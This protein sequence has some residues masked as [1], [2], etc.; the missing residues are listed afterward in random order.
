MKTSSL[1]NQRHQARQIQ[2]YHPAEVG[3]PGVRPAAPRAPWEMCYSEWE[4]GCGE[5]LTRT[6]ALWLCVC[7]FMSGQFGFLYLGAKI[8]NK[9]NTDLGTA[10]KYR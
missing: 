7:S 3:I 1:K 8:G 9:T 4:E 6:Q 2:E 5:E 10:C